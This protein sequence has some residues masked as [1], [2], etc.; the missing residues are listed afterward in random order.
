MKNIGKCG[1]VFSLLMAVFV[2]PSVGATSTRIADNLDS[3]Q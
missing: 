1:L 2:A 3:A